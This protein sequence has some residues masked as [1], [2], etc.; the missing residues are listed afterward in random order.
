LQHLLSAHNRLK[1]EYI[2]LDRRLTALEQAG[3]AQQLEITNLLRR[4]QN[5]FPIEPW[6]DAENTEDF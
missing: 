3:T 1:R 2:K 6:K 4:V 5:D